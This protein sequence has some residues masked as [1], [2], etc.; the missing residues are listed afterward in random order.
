MKLLH[1][2]FLIGAPSDDDL[3][4]KLAANPQGF[5]GIL[6][7]HLAHA[8]YQQLSKRIPEGRERFE[9][10]WLID[11]FHYAREA[12]GSDRFPE[13]AEYLNGS[14]VWQNAAPHFYDSSVYTRVY[15]PMLELCKKSEAQKLADILNRNGMLRAC[16]EKR[17]V[18]AQLIVE[19]Y[20]VTLAG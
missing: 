8:S 5:T 10:E 2:R 17:G 9:F 13:F 19:R 3:K 15:E 11:P 20:G 1:H 4:Q 12:I 14:N 16:F 6:D 7:A 18:P